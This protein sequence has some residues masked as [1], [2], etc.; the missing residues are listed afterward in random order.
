MKG[1]KPKPIRE[2]AVGIVSRLNVPLDGPITPRLQRP[3]L[4]NAIGFTVDYAETD[5]ETCRRKAAHFGED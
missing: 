2:R 1:Q 4:T 3:Q 5:T